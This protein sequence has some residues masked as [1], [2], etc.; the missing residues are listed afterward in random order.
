M[1]SLW[2]FS[3]C[4]YPGFD[5]FRELFLIRGRSCWSCEFDLKNL[6]ILWAIILQ[7][8][9]E[10]NYFDSICYSIDD[11]SFCDNDS[12]LIFLFK[13]VI[14]TYWTYRVSYSKPIKV[15]LLWWRYW[16]WFLLIFW[17]VCVHEKGTFMPNSPVFIYTGW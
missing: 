3:N 9:A 10:K 2:S 13:I 12:L 5:F 7:N 1:Y 15:I 8:Q 6:V 4:M 16:L 11:T 14:W 17:I